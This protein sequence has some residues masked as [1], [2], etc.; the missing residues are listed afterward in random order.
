MGESIVVVGAA[1]SADVDAPTERVHFAPGARRGQSPRQ[2]TGA[3]AGRESTEDFCVGTS[4][5][6][7]RSSH[8]SSAAA[9]AT[10]HRAAGEVGEAFTP[11][12]AVAQGD[13]AL[14]NGYPA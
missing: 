8:A 13:T 4:I 5:R 9:A 2:P 14:E 7:V 6:G 3:R 12:Q 11:G 10:G 1:L